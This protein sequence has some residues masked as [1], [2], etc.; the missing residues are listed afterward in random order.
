MDVLLIMCIGVL[1][2]NKIFPVKYKS[3]NEK[4]QLV[5]TL[6]LIF[7]MGVMLGKRENFIKELASLGWT[8]FCFFLIPSFVSVIFVYFLTRKYLE[9]KGKKK[10]DK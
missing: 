6:L 10:G 9:K 5:C 3:I 7:S 4:L 1:I 2:G 8:S